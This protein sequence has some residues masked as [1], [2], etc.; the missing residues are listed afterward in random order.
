MAYRRID[1]SGKYL[2]FFILQIVCVEF[3]KCVVFNNSTDY[4]YILS[5][6]VIK[7]SALAL[8]LFSFVSPI[9]ITSI[10]DYHIATSVD[11][12]SNFQIIFVVYPDAEGAEFLGHL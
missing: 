10:G 8:W 4:Q 9:M 1:K 11:A 12:N 5:H 7:F 6:F 3:Q 2:N